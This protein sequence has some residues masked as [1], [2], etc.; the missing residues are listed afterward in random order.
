MIGS[1]LEALEAEHEQLYQSLLRPITAF[2]CELLP[3][4]MRESSSGE[5]Y[6]EVCVLAA[7]QRSSCPRAS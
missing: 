2:L 1:M 4:D 5:L 3:E 6:Y 7:A